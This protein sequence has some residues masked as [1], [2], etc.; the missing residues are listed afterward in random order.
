MASTETSGEKICG[1]QSCQ[2]STN[3]KVTKERPYPPRFLS[4]CS[5]FSLSPSLEHQSERGLGGATLSSHGETLQM[6]SE[7]LGPAWFPGSG[8]CLRLTPPLP[9]C[10]SAPSL[11]R[12]L[13]A[14]G[15]LCHFVPSLC[16]AMGQPGRVSTGVCALPQAAS[17]S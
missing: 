11:P 6:Q 16:L 8:R 14:P 7:S 9:L 3:E 12:Q 1:S 10:Q 5:C 2:V 15:H 13:S 17:W 4:S